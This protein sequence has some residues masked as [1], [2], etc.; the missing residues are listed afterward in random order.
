MRIQKKLLDLKS[1]EATSPLTLQGIHS[2]EE[3]EDLVNANLT[4]DSNG[5]A[6]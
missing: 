5:N 4:N 3:A 2:Q 1:S 6:N